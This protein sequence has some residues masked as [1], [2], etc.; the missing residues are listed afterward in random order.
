MPR[1]KTVLQLLNKFSLGVNSALVIRDNTLLTPD[2]R[3]NPDDIITLR[4]V[5][6]SG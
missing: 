5:T 2:R 3:I 4:I 6:S 1:C